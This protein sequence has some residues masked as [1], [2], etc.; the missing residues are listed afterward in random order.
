M[1]AMQQMAA[2]QAS[3]AMHLLHAG[4]NMLLMQ[5]GVLAAGCACG[6]GSR[7]SVRIAALPTK[8]WRG[9]SLRHIPPVASK[10]QRCRGLRHAD[11]NRYRLW[12]GS[13]SRSHRRPSFCPRR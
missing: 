10:S 6:A 3:T 9:R 11:P 12:M 5:S 7:R 4:A 1:T 8:N 13:K 2:L